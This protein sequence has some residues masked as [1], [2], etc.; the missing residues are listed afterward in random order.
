MFSEDRKLASYFA[1]VKA[2]E[3]H[4]CMAMAGELSTTD[5]TIQLVLLAMLAFEA[6]LTYDEITTAIIEG[7]TEGNLL[8]TS[9]Q[10]RSDPDYWRAV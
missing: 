6:G 2:A 8:Y 1:I 9:L 10:S 5:A 4:T 7:E 3:I